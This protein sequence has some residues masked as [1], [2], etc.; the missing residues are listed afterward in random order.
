MAQGFFFRTSGGAEIDLL[1]VLG[2]G[3][4]WAIEIQRGVHPKPRRGFHA[5]CATLQ[6]TRRFVVYPGAERFPVAPDIEA[7]PLR[8][9]ARGLAGAG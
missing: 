9:L 7:I 8:D 2:D 3:T 1:I 4:M 6:P 5:G